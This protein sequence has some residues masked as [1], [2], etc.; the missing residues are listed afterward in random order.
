MKERSEKA[1]QRPLQHCAGLPEE[2]V[3]KYEF[4][5]A[6][7]E[8]VSSLIEKERLMQPRQCTHGVSELSLG[9]VSYLPTFVARLQCE[10]GRI[11]ISSKSISLI[12]ISQKRGRCP[13]RMTTNV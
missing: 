8:S 1:A 11:E 5:I 7:L 4:S 2:K 13:F 6:L 9:R 10:H 12:L 3:C